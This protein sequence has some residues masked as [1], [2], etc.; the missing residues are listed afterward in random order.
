MY[1][2][3]YSTVDGS[4]FHAVLPEMFVEKGVEVYEPSQEVVDAYADYVHTNVWPEISSE[5]G[6]IWNDIL[7]EVNK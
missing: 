1:T 4:S 7:A 2:I 6:D 5:Y 3:S